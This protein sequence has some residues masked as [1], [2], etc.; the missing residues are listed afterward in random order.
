MFLPLIPFRGVQEISNAELSE[1]S[2]SF[3][4]KFQ[5][6]LYL[7]IKRKNKNKTEEEEEVS[8]STFHED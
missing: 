4:V 6:A 5:H 7:D 2:V 3:N 1:L 8:S